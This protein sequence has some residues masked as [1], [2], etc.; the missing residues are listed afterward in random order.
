MNGTP[1]HRV[2][3]VS[4]SLNFVSN[5]GSNLTLKPSFGGGSLG[6]STTFLPLDAP[7]V[8]AGGLD[9]LKANAGGYDTALSPDGQGTE[10]S[11]INSRRATSVLATIRQEIAPWLEAYL[12]LLW[13]Q[14]DGTASVLAANTAINQLRSGS[15]ANPFNQLVNFSFP[16][17]GMVGRAQTLTVT[18]RMSAG[19]IVRLG[20]GWS[21]NLDA[22]LGEARTSSSMTSDRRK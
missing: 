9:I 4:P 14:N 10:Q 7:S 16:T 12:D 3:L 6:A 15:P 11:L 21:A 19:L 2:S 13:L 1:D 22:A 5:D 18:D 8:T 17:P 20:G